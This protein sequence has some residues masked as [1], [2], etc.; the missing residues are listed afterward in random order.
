[1]LAAQRDPAVPAWPV[2]DL[3]VSRAQP[4]ATPAR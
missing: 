4:I 1:V 2:G 3:I